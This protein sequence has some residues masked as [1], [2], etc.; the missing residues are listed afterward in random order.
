MSLCRLHGNVDVTP[1]V[2]VQVRKEGG[3]EEAA[4]AEAA[5]EA[6]SAP[7]P[8]EETQLDASPEAVEAGDE[9]AEAEQ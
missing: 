5:P 6:A 3:T 8:T 4:A 7:S 9:N 1:N 2:K